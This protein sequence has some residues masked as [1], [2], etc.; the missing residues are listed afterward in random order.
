MSASESITITTFRDELADDFDRINRAWLVAGGYLEPADE[1]YLD[2]PRAKII[3]VGGEIFFAML[4]TSVVGTAAAIPLGA[5]VFELAKVG[6]T[7][8]AQGR[9]LGRLLT[10]AAIE[11]ARQRGAARVVLTSNQRLTAAVAL[12]RSLG[13]AEMPCPP[14]FGYVTADIYMELELPVARTT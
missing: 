3:D 2:A 7:P 8:S 12:Y 1:V 6:V 10:M 13:F 5:D 4:G 9:G 11:Y 14:G